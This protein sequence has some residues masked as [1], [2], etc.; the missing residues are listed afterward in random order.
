MMYV[1][2]RKT[3]WTNG[4]RMTELVCNS[5][6]EC[7]GRVDCSRIQGAW[8]EGMP[9]SLDYV[10]APILEKIDFAKLD[11]ACM[12]TVFQKAKWDAAIE[13]MYVDE[14]HPSMVWWTVVT[15][16]F[17][18]AFLCFKL[19]SD[20]VQPKRMFSAYSSKN[21]HGTEMEKTALKT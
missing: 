2:F 4:L 17:L 15:V 6:M 16:V 9:E 18:N 11:T 7:V 10:R 3:A 8:R 14:I 13:Q 5:L 12:E 1:H 21:E 19:W 20:V